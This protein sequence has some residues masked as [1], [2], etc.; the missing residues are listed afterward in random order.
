MPRSCPSKYSHA[1]GDISNTFANILD[2]GDPLLDLSERPGE[3]GIP[4][5]RG[6]VDGRAGVP[7]W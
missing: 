6:A 3:A 1:S 5:E 4:T 2:E 7:R